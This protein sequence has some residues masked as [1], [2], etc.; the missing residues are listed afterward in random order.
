M[1]VGAAWVGVGDT[2]KIPGRLEDPQHNCV[3]YTK[4]KGLIQNAT[5]TLTVDGTRHEGDGNLQVLDVQERTH[6]LQL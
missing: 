1:T 5:V 3:T 6:C 2:E 4:I